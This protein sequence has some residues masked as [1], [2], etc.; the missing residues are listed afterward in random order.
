MANIHYGRIGDVWK[1]L[2]LAEILTIER[3]HHVWESHAGSAFY[4]LTP[5]YERDYGVY[6]VRARAADAPHLAESRYVDLLRSLETEGQIR[7][8]PGSP[9]IA[10]HLLG[11]ESTDFV[12]CDTDPD[13]LADIQRAAERLGITPT[14]LRLVNGDGLTALTQL[15][16]DLAPD[17]AAVTLAHIDPY[18]T[19]LS[20]DSG[21]NS[22]DLLCH[23]SAHG[24]RC[25]LWYGYVGDEDR[26]GIFAGLHRALDRQRT[27]ASA[28]RLW[29]GDIRLDAAGEPSLAANTGVISCGIITAHLGERS[30]NACNQLGRALEQIYAD[31]RLMG[32]YSGALHYTS[33]PVI[34]R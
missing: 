6:R 22:F 11:D 23:L 1:H 31:A 13:S 19:L 27:S 3:P 12:F 17:E 10:M 8:Y 34:D 24:V 28:L 21:R 18:Q 2:P 5:S 14:R 7:I 30:I 32:G 20:D 26:T 4:H 16:D 29:N 9:A 33:A 25:V 15:G